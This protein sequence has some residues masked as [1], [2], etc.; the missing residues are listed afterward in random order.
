M[1]ERRIGAPGQHAARVEARGGTLRVTVRCLEADL[2]RRGIP[3]T[4]KRLL[5]G[6][7]L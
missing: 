4:S 6:P 7:P 1:N 5:M 3:L 2:E